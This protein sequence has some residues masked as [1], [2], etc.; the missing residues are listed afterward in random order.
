MEAI[1][2]K[3]SSNQFQLLLQSPNPGGIRLTTKGGFPRLGRP[4]MWPSGE[5]NPTLKS[6]ELTSHS[7]KDIHKADQTRRFYGPMQSR[8]MH[9]QRRPSSIRTRDLLSGK[10]VLY[11]CAT[12]PHI[13]FFYLRPGHHR[14]L[15]GWTLGADVHWY[16]WVW[17]LREDVR[18]YQGLLGQGFWKVKRQGLWE[19]SIN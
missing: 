17:T 13:A 5:P 2:F 6:Q 14:E 19:K 10:R 15:G 3:F 1:F 16:R 12:R 18:W 11:H 8:C 9:T 7:P 4:T